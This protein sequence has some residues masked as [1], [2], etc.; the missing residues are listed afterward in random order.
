MRDAVQQISLA[1]RRRPETAYCWI[2]LCLILP[3][4]LLTACKGAPEDGVG[5]LISEPD[6]RTPPPPPGVVEEA[7]L[8]LADQHLLAPFWRF[9][10]AGDVQAGVRFLESLDHSMLAP[11]D[12]FE[13]QLAQLELS[14]HQDP[15]VVGY[16]LQ[17]LFPLPDGAD[18]PA[19]QIHRLRLR[20]ASLRGRVHLRMMDYEAA[21]RQWSSVFPWLPQASWPQAVAAIW[22]IL[23]E[24]PVFEV[25]RFLDGAE[26]G[27]Q[28]EG[29]Y[30][31]L[32]QT[33]AEAFVQAQYQA[34]LDWRQHWR[35]HP[36]AIHPPEALAVLPEVLRQRP[37]RIAVLLPTSGPLAAYGEAVRD[38]L[39]AAYLQQARKDVQLIF[40]D[41]AAISI[42][43]AYE[44]AIR[45]QVDAIIGPL[46]KSRLASMLEVIAGEIPV[47]SLNYLPAEAVPPSGLWQFGLAAEDEIKQIA[48][49]ALGNGL[50]R[51]ALLYAGSD[52]ARRG[53]GYFR[54]L[55]AAGGGDLIADSELTT[56]DKV[57]EAVAAA[58][59][60]TES[61]QR[62]LDVRRTIRRETAFTIRR[63]QDIDLVFLLSGNVL[64]NAIKPAL[65]YYFSGDIPVY[66][67]HRIVADDKGEEQPDL[68]GIRYG[69]LPWRLRR[70]DLKQELLAS[71]PNANGNAFSFYALGVDA[72]ALVD[73]MQH[74]LRVANLRV[75]GQTGW[76]R[77]HVDGRFQRVLE[78]AEIDAGLPRPLTDLQRAADAL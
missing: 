47:L 10:D 12:D 59:L 50:R 30:Q 5:P 74:F 32:L 71:F 70:S 11:Q 17:E 78:I 31:L 55:W 41:T 3:V 64:A 67:T 6:D 68:D 61:A 37:Q 54:E 65:R 4:L 48:A 72:M 16:L 9:V 40:L 26:Q 38:G 58:L 21:I 57:A 51:A 18:L 15:S 2:S 29:W 39:L 20:E 34:Y 77:H 13:L 7:P 33:D 1:N 60:T 43:E 69:E 49:H 63:R 42:A 22:A 66:S 35:E 24:R 76:I 19:A 44:Q 53:A 23:S 45:D 73:R 8:D 27:S 62:D 28:L 46:D 75:R 56:P 14:L 36:A 25:R 52:W